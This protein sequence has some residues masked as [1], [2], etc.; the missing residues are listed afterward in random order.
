MHLQKD[1]IF[2]SNAAAYYGQLQVGF[3][4][5]TQSAPGA[6]SAARMAERLRA[7]EAQGGFVPSVAYD[8][9]GILEKLA[10]DNAIDAPP[11]LE[12]ANRAAGG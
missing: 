3:M 2:S 8:L 6:Y 7:V 1:S 5:A 4:G 9:L 11:S 12:S 10:P